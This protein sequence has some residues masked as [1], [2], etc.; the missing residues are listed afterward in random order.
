MAKENAEYV[1]VG[2]KDVIRYVTSCFVALGKSDTI[3]IISRGNHIKR[4]LDVLAILKRE[5]LENPKYSIE[6]DSEPFENRF[7]TSIEITVSGKKK[8][9][10]K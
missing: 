4:A 9:E 5:H 8:K 2:N 7:V 6:I 10:S 3:K 1:Y